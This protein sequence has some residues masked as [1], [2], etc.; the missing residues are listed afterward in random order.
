GAR[1]SELEGGGRQAELGA[2]EHGRGLLKIVAGVGADRVDVAPGPLDRIV[3]IDGP[4]A[5]GLEQAVDGVDGSI[6]GL[7]AVPPIARPLGPRDLP[8]LAREAHRLGENT[9]AP[10]A[11][12]R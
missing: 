5:A 7:R 8:P 3:E 9:E 1:R 12:P 6:R 2:A 10:P 4:A 11:G